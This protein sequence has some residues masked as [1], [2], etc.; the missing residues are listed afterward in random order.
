MELLYSKHDQLDDSYNR[1]KWAEIQSAFTSFDSIV[2]PLINKIVAINFAFH[3]VFNIDGAS[4]KSLSLQISKF[5]SEDL[6]A[7][8]SLSTIQNMNINLA[9]TKV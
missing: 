5:H 1:Q 3:A 9:L 6:D 7:L 4:K 8:L 2:S